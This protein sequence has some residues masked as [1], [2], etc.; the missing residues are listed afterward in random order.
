MQ[1]LSRKICRVLVSLQV[2]PNLKQERRL[3]DE[4]LACNELSIVANICC[5]IQ[6]QTKFS[7]T[8]HRS[9]SLL[10]NIIRDGVSSTRGEQ[11]LYRQVKFT[12]FITQ[13]AGVILDKVFVLEINFKWLELLH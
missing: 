1:K 12:I 5:L 6:L 9:N 10:Q 3:G 7:T 11:F 13:H 8:L 4:E 2:W